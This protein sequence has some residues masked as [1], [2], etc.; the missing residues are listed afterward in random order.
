MSNTI[1]MSRTITISADDQKKICK[2]FAIGQRIKEIADANDLSMRTVEAV[3]RDA[4]LHLLDQTE[5][6]RA[7]QPD[8]ALVARQPQDIETDVSGV[9]MDKGE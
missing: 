1:P 7:F 5:A 9:P 8:P 6:L 4:L 3:I 2:A